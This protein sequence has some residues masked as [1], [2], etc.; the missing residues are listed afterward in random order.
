MSRSAVLTS[1]YL[2]P[3][4]GAQQR[5]RPIGE[6]VSS[7]AWRRVL[8]EEG[9]RGVPKGVLKDIPDEQGS[10]AFICTGGLTYMYICE[11]RG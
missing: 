5:S 6:M 4:T 8:G 7:S 10:K 9:Q 11:P 2:W 3:G 1:I